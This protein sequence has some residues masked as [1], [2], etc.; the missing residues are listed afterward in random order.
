MSNI[1]LRGDSEKAIP[2]RRNLVLFAI[3]MVIGIIT[4]DITKSMSY[5]L[6][7]SLFLGLIAIILIRKNQILILSLSGILLFY[8]I[9]ATRYI[10]DIKSITGKFEKFN[11][12]D[13][14]VVAVICS[15]PEYKNGNLRFEVLTES[16]TNKD[17]GTDKDTRGIIS[18]THNIKGKILVTVTN[19]IAGA[20]EIFEPGQKI[21]LKGKL[22]LPLGKRNPGGLD[23]KKYLAASGISATMYTGKHNVKIIDTKSEVILKAIGHNLR[24]RIIMAVNE[25]LPEQQAAFLNAMLTGYREGIS[26]ELEGYFSDSGI[27]HI[28]SVSGLH[29]A[30]IMMPFIYIFKKIGFKKKN[31][32]LIVMVVLIM[33]VL[34]TGPQPSV[35]R[36]VIMA[37]TVLAGQIM[38]REPDTLT[39][40]SFSCILILLWRPLMLYNIGFEL[41]YAATVSIVLLNKSIN[42]GIKK[43]VRLRFIPAKVRDNIFGILSTTLAAQAGTFPISA[44][45]FNKFSLISVFTNLLAVPLSG[46]IMVLGM[47]TAVLGQ[48]HN[49]FAKALGFVNLP[50]IN[51]LFHIS[52]IAAGLPFA[53]LR[54]ITPSIITIVLYYGLIWFLWMKSKYNF[55]IKPEYYTILFLLIITAGVVAGMIPK[56]LEVVFLDVGE[57][58]SAFI[59]TP[60]GK[61]VLIDGG[62][63]KGEEPGSSDSTGNR[64][65]IP[66]LL[67]YGVIKLDVVVATH[68]HDD[69]IKGIESVLREIRVKKLVIPDYGNADGGFEE[70]LNICAERGIQVVKAKRN[71]SIKLDSGVSLDILNPPASSAGTNNKSE[72]YFNNAQISL[73]NTSIVLKLHYKEVDILFTGDIEEEA[74]KELIRNI[75][76]DVGADVLKVPHHGSSTSSTEEFIEYVAPKVAVI[77]VGKYNNYGHPSKEVLDRLIA[78]GTTVFRTDLHGAVII[79]TNGKI[80]TVRVMLEN[81]L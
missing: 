14:T 61:T 81:G 44:V 76:D 2:M 7:V 30:Y 18:G 68:A 51:L 70:L 53:I 9:G 74:E 22:T 60:S 20:E 25:S 12:K 58:D 41:S 34:I 63:K 19:I 66:F 57:G 50:M 65:I 55:R 38:M 5:I 24:K 37:L 69:H 46:V 39:S 6:A 79:K 31:A 17:M 8:I 54:M 23:Y 45:Y 71:H 36:A 16:I 72:I 47:A 21:Q 3:A 62:G 40:I 48:I 49:T 42:E 64:V 77:S 80:I 43:R 10:Y 78:R 59:K 56:K 1:L 32:N 33:Y 13:V 27:I 35:L 26:E 15:E 73:N 29:V 75:P 67:E 11:E 4:A 52:K 28:L